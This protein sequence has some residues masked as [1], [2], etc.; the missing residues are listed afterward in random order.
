MK[1]DTLVN[2]I[3]LDDLL[4]PKEESVTNMVVES[5]QPESKH[6]TS[7]MP[8]NIDW[9]DIISEWFYR[10][11]KGYAEHP[12]SDEELVVLNQVIF[13]HG[14]DVTNNIIVEASFTPSELNRDK[15]FQAFIDRISAGEPFT[16]E[17]DKTKQVIDKSFLDTMT[18]IANVTDFDERL[19]L[20]K[21]TF[22]KPVI[23]L[24]N[25]TVVKLSD[26]SKDTFT[27]KQT[28]SG[29]TG[30]E[31]P[32]FKEG[33]VVFFYTCPEK[34]LNVVY[35]FL[36]GS[37]DSP[38][39]F[40]NLINKMKVD[41]Y[42]SK[43]YGFVKAGVELLASGSELDQKT[44]KLFLNAVSAA[45]TIKQKWGEG[46]V[47]DRGTFF[48]SIRDAANAITGI[49]KDKWCPGDVYL[50]KQN[51]K[52]EIERVV[53][54]SEKTNS[55][56]NI[57]DKRNKVLQVGL[58]S[59][60]DTESPL[61]IAVSLKEENALSGRAKDF[62]SVKKLSNTEM[63]SEKGDFTKEEFA[64][65]SGKVKITPELAQKYQTQYNS[66]KKAYA[67]L[68]KKFGYTHN[69]AASKFK[70]PE[71]AVAIRNTII[72]SAA[73]R[74]MAKY[75]NSFDTLK[76][77][78]DVMKNYKDPFLALTA[79]GVS[80]SGF[81]PTFYKVVASASGDYG[82]VTVFEGRDNLKAD[83]DSVTT[84][85]TPTKAG[86]YLSFIT[87][88]GETKYQTKLDIR[89]SKSGASITIAI[90]VDEFHEA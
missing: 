44:K 76:G 50:Y 19:A 86:I 32:D 87:K 78:N 25:N 38:P 12:Y 18:Q 51:D 64:L 72:K 59:L 61:V 16:L 2:I 6:D 73:Y 35:N 88:M 84:I 27:A 57:V 66:S 42:G 71:P 31:T 11:P 22:K 9:D 65:I 81:N 55:I 34:L 80:L 52:A 23:P 24:A 89:E 7:T 69:F 33:L 13:E 5:I 4:N 21:N 62:L 47:I 3:D 74:L 40:G 39:D 58:N 79:Y 20:I 68:I 29:L 48:E 77:I 1:K 53:T 60:F 37:D 63:G 36:V 56:I 8:I 83:S 46:Y 28:T 82:H 10:L 90:I 49:P 54:E 43:S 15:Y 70:E 26:I 14:Y 41:H 67:A 85:D 75:F 17:P 30:T 45:Y